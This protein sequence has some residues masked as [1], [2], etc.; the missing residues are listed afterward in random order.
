MTF[1]YN[2]NVSPLSA[3][4]MVRLYVGDVDGTDPQ[5]QDGEITAILLDEGGDVM[6]AACTA[7]DTIGSRYARQA[8]EGNRQADVLMKHYLD[9]AT[10]LRRKMARTGVLPFSGGQSNAAKQQQA[11]NPDQ[12][13]PAFTKGMD[14]EP[15]T[16]P[17]TTTNPDEFPLPPY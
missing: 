12:V 11:Q 6:R 7:A 16:W 15:G 17:G 9:L 10:R 14:S 8:S 5:L 1:S 13:Q 3:R 2:P 4:D